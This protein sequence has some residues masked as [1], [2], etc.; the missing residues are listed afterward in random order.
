M[1]CLP[2]HSLSVANSLSLA[3]EGV[4]RASLA[5]RCRRQVGGRVVL[6]CC[7]ASTGAWFPHDLA[8]SPLR[9]AEAVEKALTASAGMFN[10]LLLRAPAPD[11]LAL[12][13]F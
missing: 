2:K 10:P 9:A 4:A 11:V 7:Y 12:S 13:M 5:L 8:R 6:V 3:G 1:K